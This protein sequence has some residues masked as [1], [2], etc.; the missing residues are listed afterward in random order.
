MINSTVNRT[1]N[2]LLVLLLSCLVTVAHGEYAGPLDDELSLDADEQRRQNNVSYGLILGQIAAHNAAI[3]F[4][5]APEPFTSFT[6][7]TI[8]NIA[9]GGLKY[10]KAYLV[11]PPDLAVTPQANGGCEFELAIPQTRALFTNNLGFTPR[12]RDDFLLIPESFPSF[13]DETIS[14]GPLGVPEIVH[15]NTDVVLRLD[16]LTAGIS[17]FFAD[18]DTTSRTFMVQAGDHE[19]VWRAE[20]QVKPFFDLLVPTVMT[21]LMASAEFKFG[22]YLKSLKAQR[23]ARNPNL[24]V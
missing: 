2:G 15:A 17:S 23:R 6:A 22:K 8:M 16:G 3:P 18:A 1:R 24:A 9:D 4:G 21:P 14:Y 19:L 20:T 11:A 10:T 5:F 7:E 13:R 12:L